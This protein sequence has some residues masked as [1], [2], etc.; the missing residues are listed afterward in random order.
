MD[1]GSIPAAST[2]LPSEE[3]QHR[4]TATEKQEGSW[5]PLSVLLLLFLVLLFPV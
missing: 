3:V 4:G 1:A 5:E 2:I